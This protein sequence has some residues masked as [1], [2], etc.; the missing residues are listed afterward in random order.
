VTALN[1]ENAR[2][3]DIDLKLIEFFNLNPRFYQED[4]NYSKRDYFKYDRA[5]PSE[6][7]AKSLEGVTAHDLL[8][9]RRV[10]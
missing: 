3:N 7:G 4:F 9:M 2:K 10:L 6:L 8:M 5:P 1:P